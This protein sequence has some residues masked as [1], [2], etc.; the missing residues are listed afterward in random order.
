MYEIAYL[1][2]TD[3]RRADHAV[4][5][6]TGNVFRD[7]ERF[8]AGRR[9]A[10]NPATARAWEREFERDILT[11][12][13]R[14]DVYYSAARNELASYGYALEPAG[15]LYRVTRPPVGP[16]PVSAVWERYVTRGIAVVEENPAVP[17]YTADKWPR[18]AVCK[19]KSM[20]AEGYFLAGEREKA[21]DILAAA[22]PAAAGISSALA[23]IAR[24]YFNNGYP[25]QAA[26][27][28]D[29]AARNFPRRGVGDG[30]WRRL[31]A[32]V[33]ES[34][35][36][37]ALHA[38]DVDGAEAAYKESL[39]AYPDQPQLRVAATRENLERAARELNSRD[40]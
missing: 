16:R 38:G 35:G 28:Y 26:V 5:D 21:L 12:A 36:T 1:K 9:E 7:Y 31:Y 11:S 8:A 6:A 33:L 2:K 24:I 19:Y 17:R 30:P 34:K 14:R 3:G 20:L 32:R 37:A 10:G 39:A 40:E 15:M 18:E 27:Y 29:L 13:D 4:V 23:E 25:A 22:A